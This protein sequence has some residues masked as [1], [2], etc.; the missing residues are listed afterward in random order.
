MSRGSDGRYVLIF[1]FLGGVCAFAWSV[2][3][4]RISYSRVGE[5]PLDF[6]S[7]AISLFVNPGFLFAFTMFLF[8]FFAHKMQLLP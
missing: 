2:L 3:V 8:G 5:G 4:T 1:F 6:S 7:P